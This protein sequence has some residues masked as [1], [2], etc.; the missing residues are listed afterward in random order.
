MMAQI[1]TD[2]SPVISVE[3]E[4]AIMEINTV[5]DVVLSIVNSGVNNGPERSELIFISN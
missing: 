3:N 1:M 2:N 4:P 5:V